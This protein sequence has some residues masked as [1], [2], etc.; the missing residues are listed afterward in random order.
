MKVNTHHPSEWRA[1]PALYIA[2]AGLLAGVLWMP[3]SFLA[4]AAGSSTLEEKIIVSLAN[5]SW[6]DDTLYAMNPDGTGMNAIFD[7]HSHPR[8]PTGRIWQPRVGPDGET[9][10]FSS[11]N[12]H[13]YTPAD[14]N[15]F[16]V[17]SGGSWWDQIT[18]GPNSG[19]WN[20]PCP[21][22][23]VEGFVRK[24]EGGIWA[25][26]PVYLEGVGM[27]SAGLDGF[28]RFTNVPQGERWI[29]AYR[30]GGSTMFDAQ[31]ISAT[32][33]SVTTI[34]L[35]PDLDVR[36]NYQYPVIHADTH[37]PSERVY[38]KFG[39]NMIQWT[40]INATTY[41]TVYSTTGSCIG[42]PDVDGFD[43]GA[44]SGNLLIAD[45][46]DGC[47]G[48]RGIYA[49]TG[50]GDALHLLVD[51]KADPQWCGVQEV[52]WSPDE[53]KIAFK[54]CYAAHTH[55]AVHNAFTGGLIDHFYFRDP[56]APLD[57]VAFHGWSPDGRWL[58]VSSWP[59]D[60]NRGVLSKIQV[61]PDGTFDDPPVMI[62]LLIGTRISGATWGMI[63]PPEPQEQKVHL[64][65]IL[66][67]H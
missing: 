63:S 56:S 5:E 32:P 67:L 44:S 17:A 15:L 18:P 24:S 51:M 60:P 7:F 33:A 20:A 45:Y 46:Q 42:I 13:L 27:R 19:V 66:R 12:T 38:H 36:R 8:Q 54:A 62:H 14:R 41:T 59:G 57:N 28:F 55:I 52:Y 23:S 50:D 61:G 37:P 39:L 10:L 3:G 31:V 47:A 21:C 2:L 4:Q 49:A 43:V 1:R 34:D 58:L 53:T 65:I 22:G 26:S 29:V 25:N 11:D 30:P 9:I 48:H 35:T 6:T 40:D 16:R 64:P